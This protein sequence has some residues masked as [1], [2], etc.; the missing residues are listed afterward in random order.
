MSDV[1]RVVENPSWTVDTGC[2]YMSVVPP[3]G[4]E[5]RV[6]GAAS[7][8]KVLV[9]GVQSLLVSIMGKPL[10]VPCCGK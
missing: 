6:G 9:G 10:D 5:T 2:P 1:R 7:A 8:T 4:R 3:L